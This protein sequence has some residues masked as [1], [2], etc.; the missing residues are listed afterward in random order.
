MGKISAGISDFYLV[1]EIPGIY[2]GMMIAIEPA[3][4]KVF[5][6][7]DRLQLA[8]VLLDLARR[9]RLIDFI[10]QPRAPKKKK[11][12]P[13]WDPRHRNVSTA[14]LLKMASR[15]PRS[16]AFLPTQ[17]CCVGSWTAV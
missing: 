8:D 16:P 4:W 13:V 7:I 3:H 15:S 12:P 11:A 14:R 10:K 5:A 6:S 2:R 9:V 17:R 1:N